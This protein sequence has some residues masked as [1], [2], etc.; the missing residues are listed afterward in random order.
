[1]IVTINYDPTR[2]IKPGVQTQFDVTQTPIIENIGGTS[3]PLPDSAD[4]Q[5]EQ[6]AGASVLTEAQVATSLIAGFRSATPNIATVD[7]TGRVKQVGNGVV[8]IIADGQDMSKSVLCNVSLVGGQ[9]TTNVVNYLPGW[10]SRKLSD[11]LDAKI[12]GT[13]ANINGPLLSSWSPL[14]RNVN[15]WATRV[16]VDTTPICMLQSVSGSHTPV[17]LITP[18]H[19]IGCD[20]GRLSVGSWVQWLAQD[21]TNR[22]CQRTIIGS[23]QTQYAS[24]TGSD[25]RVYVLD[26]DV[27]DFISFMHVL[28]D[29]WFPK[30][31]STRITGHQN[32]AYSFTLPELVTNQRK[33]AGVYNWGEDVNSPPNEGW[34]VYDFVATSGIRAQYG[35]AIIMGDSGNPKCLILNNKLILLSMISSLVIWP[36]KTHINNA[37]NSLGNNP[38]NYQLTSADFSSYPSYP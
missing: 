21:G 1:M 33:F 25:G 3:T 9:V 38:N 4:K 6:L 16:G 13:D 5:M 22:I 26:S 34:T 31:P 30:L 11:D 35:F 12:T 37:I 36:E 7:A 28:P 14:T 29:N 8:R 2:A 23:V 27:D 18:R 24:G 15:N 10:L 19:A 17:N 20:H 32:P